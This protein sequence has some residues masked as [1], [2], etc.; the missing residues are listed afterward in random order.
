ME[1]EPRVEPGPRV[2]RP[3]TSRAARTKLVPPGPVAPVERPGTPRAEGPGP[4]PPASAG[5]EGPVP[6][7]PVPV[8]PV[9]V[10]VPVP[11]G[12]EG[13]VSGRPVVLG[14]PVVLVAAPR[15]PAAGGRGGRGCCWPSSPWSSSG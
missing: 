3:E 4:V 1:P 11:V 6:G 13:P 14:L 15:V 2:N 5:P 7:R 12:P 9:P 10:P 8:V